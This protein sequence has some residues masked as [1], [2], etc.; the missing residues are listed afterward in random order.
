MLKALVYGNLME[1]KLRIVSN[2]KAETLKI[3]LYAYIEK[4]KISK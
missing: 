3:I 4:N 1:I 2:I